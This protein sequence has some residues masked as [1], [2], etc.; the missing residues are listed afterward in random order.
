MPAQ[1]FVLG[2]RQRAVYQFVEKRL[3]MQVNH[4]RLLSISSVKNDHANTLK[5]PRAADPLLAPSAPISW[6]RVRK[7]ADE[8]LSRPA[9]APSNLMSMLGCAGSVLVLFV[10]LRGVGLPAAIAVRPRSLI[11][12]F[13]A[14]GA[15]RLALLLS[16][17]PGVSHLVAV[18]R[19]GAV[20]LVLVADACDLYAD[21]A[22]VSS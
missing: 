18:L 17:L 1:P 10:Y 22:L 16:A 14:L 20:T 3:G 15:S 19:L 8:Q 13:E 5:S 6:R 2:K 12:L 4:H 21:R 9:N 11:A 7:T